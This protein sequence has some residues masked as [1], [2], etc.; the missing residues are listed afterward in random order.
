MKSIFNKRNTL[1][2]GAAVAVVAI[3]LIASTVLSD[4]LTSTEARDLAK[5]HVPANAEYKA[6]E[7]ESTKYEIT[8]YDATNKETYE[9][10]VSKKTQKVKSVD[11][12]LDNDLG[13]EKVTLSKAE[14]VKILKAKFS[15][16]TSISV[17]LV[18]DDGLYEYEA[19][20][21]S[22]DFY[23]D[24]TVNPAS[25]KILESSIKYGTATVIPN[26]DNDK[27]NDTSDNDSNS[28]GSSDNDA[29]SGAS[30]SDNSGSE[31]T[32]TGNDSNNSSSD[33]ISVA[34]AKSIVLAK[35]PGAT[36]KN[37]N[38]EKEDG[39]YVYEGEA[40]LGNYEYDFEINASSG[41]ISGWDKDKIDTHD[42]DNDDDNDNDEDDD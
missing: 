2:A 34:K 24:A 11:S 36:I 22:A 17:N 16:I 32:A 42:N 30:E 13:S 14:V 21:K 28:N 1:I 19:S 12:Q 29:V 10:E 23:G 7:E 41:V 38:L 4:A 15:G 35:I 27:D 5:K 33:R 37:I 26:D 6:T 31:G 20:F 8:F 18:K 3:A 39:I 9:V 25:G 40:T